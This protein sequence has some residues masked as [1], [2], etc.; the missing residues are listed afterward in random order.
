MIP[1]QYPKGQQ[2]KHNFVTYPTSYTISP[3]NDSLNSF[4]QAL[5][6]SEQSYPALQDNVF[7]FYSLIVQRHVVPSV[8]SSSTIH[9][10]P[11]F[12]KSCFNM[13]AQPSSLHLYHGPSR[14]LKSPPR[15]LGAARTLPDIRTHSF[16]RMIQLP[17]RNK[18]DVPNQ[19]PYCSQTLPC[20]D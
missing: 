20:S 8:T 3:N 10:L 12:P 15:H 11:S 2:D 5:V 16:Y 19:F 14:R 6:R 17:L 4:V 1:M 13:T 18:V 9:S 7:D